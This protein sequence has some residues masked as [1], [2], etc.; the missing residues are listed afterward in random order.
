MCQWLGVAC[1]DLPCGCQVSPRQVRTHGEAPLI[2]DTGRTL[3]LP[4]HSPPW[5]PPS[6]Y[7]PR[8]SLE[9]EVTQG[10]LVTPRGKPSGKCFSWQG[11][12]LRRP[13]AAPEIRV[14][15]E[16]LQG[17]GRGRGAGVCV[18]KDR[19]CVRPGHHRGECLSAV[20]SEEV[21]VQRQGDNPTASPGGNIPCNQCGSYAASA[22]ETSVWFPFQFFQ[23]CCPGCGPRS[24][25]LGLC[26]PLRLCSVLG[27]PE[28][29]STSGSSPQSLC[30]GWG[31]FGNTRSH[32]GG[33]GADLRLGER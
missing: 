17:G 29:S 3:L 19:F 2:S 18:S 12:T 20:F 13:T 15:A 11:V 28:G 4:P 9:A 27:K 25:G 14:E 5:P 10:F 23:A 22:S 26:Q 16:Q 30:W 24:R 33:Q 32:S 7:T 31:L 8:D 1:S 21:M 6:L